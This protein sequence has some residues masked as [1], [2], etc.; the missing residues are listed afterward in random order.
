MGRPARLSASGRLYGVTTFRW[1]ARVSGRTAILIKPFSGD[2]EIGESGSGVFR[3]SPKFKMT[4]K[5]DGML[6]RPMISIVI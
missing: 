1:R 3:A 5:S 6:F 2:K 4:K